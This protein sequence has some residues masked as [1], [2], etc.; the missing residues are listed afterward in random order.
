MSGQSKTAGIVGTSQYAGVE[1]FITEL[2]RYAN[3][4]GGFASG[5]FLNAVLEGDLFRAMAAAD[6]D[7]KRGLPMLC[8]WI[9][10]H[11]PSSAYGSREL[12]KAWRAHH[13]ISGIETAQSG[14]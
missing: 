11:M 10:T 7:S 13:G 12:V 6:S 1:H 9:H 5:G 8:T 3:R 2:Q 14:E 4:G